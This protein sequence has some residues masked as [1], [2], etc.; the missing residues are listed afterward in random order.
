ML[1][2]PT[3]AAIAAP[4]SEVSV[5]TDDDSGNIPH[6]SFQNPQVKSKG[7]LTYYSPHTIMQPKDPFPLYAARSLTFP[8]ARSER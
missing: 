7:N 4:A 3:S 6:T 5:V 8:I 2:T 1:A